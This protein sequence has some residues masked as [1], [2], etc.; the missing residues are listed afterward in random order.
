MR[1]IQ[2]SG[3]LLSRGSLG[4]PTCNGLLRYSGRLQF[5]AVHGDPLGHHSD[6]PDQANRDHDGDSDACAH[7]LAA[8]PGIGS[9]RYSCRRVSVHAEKP[10]PRPWVSH[11][12]NPR[13]GVS[14]SERGLLTVIESANRVGLEE[15]ISSVAR[16]H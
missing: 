7:L 11:P 2:R 14:F 13:G 15:S 4:L 16:D 6:R 9:T 1:N 5:G 3:C 10:R 12:L 8:F